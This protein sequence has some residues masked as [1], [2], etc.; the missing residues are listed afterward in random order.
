VCAAGLLSVFGVFNGMVK[1]DEH[2]FTA[3]A[4]TDCLLYSWSIDELALM[5]TQLAP[6]GKQRISASLS[7]LVPIQLRKAPQCGP[8]LLLHVPVRQLLLSL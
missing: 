2:M 6:A 8:P 7:Q 4:V 1:S 3:V 5:A